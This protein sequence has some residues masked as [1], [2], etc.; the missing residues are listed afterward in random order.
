MIEEMLGTAKLC[1][2]HRRGNRGHRATVTKKDMEL[3][4]SIRGRG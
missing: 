3:I 2:Q 4:A 1:A